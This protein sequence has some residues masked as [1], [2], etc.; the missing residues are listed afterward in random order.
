MGT[1]VQWLDGEEMRAW[2]AFVET[3]HDLLNAFEA[4]LAAHDLTLGDYQVLVYLSEADGQAMRM[5]D[6]AGRLRLSPS[7]LT[8]RLDGLVRSGDVVRRPSATDRRVMLAQLTE[9]GLRHLQEAAP[10]HVRSVRRRLFDHVEPDDVATLARMF[11]A[12][13]EGLEA[14]RS[15]A[16]G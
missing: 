11:G 3:T 14:S 8:R 4:D 6:L 13:G 16:S 1:D 12:V 15:T 5:C 2:R 7:G 10:T 9:T